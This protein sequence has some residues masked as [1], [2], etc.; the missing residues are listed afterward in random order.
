MS[1][2]VQFAIIKCIFMML[3]DLGSS[4]LWKLRPPGNCFQILIS[5]NHGAFG[6]NGKDAVLGSN[7]LEF[8]SRYPCFIV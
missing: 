2:E 4:N 6:C 8:K 1:M 5:D 7:S 3:L